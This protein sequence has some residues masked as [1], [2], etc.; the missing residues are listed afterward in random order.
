MSDGS[1]L[2]WLGLHRVSPGHWTFTATAPLSRA[3]RKFYGGTGVA[4]ATAIMEA[5]T[6]RR[7]IWTTVQFVASADEGDR[8]DCRIELQA[9]G[10]RSSQVRVE[11]RVEDRLV[12]SAL[13][14]T[15]EARPEQF[16]AQFRAMPDVPGPEECRRWTP[17]P[18]AHVEHTHLGW[19][20][21]VDA[22]LADE[23]G[24]MWM[25]LIDRSL[26][27]PAL[28]FLADIVPSG[29]VRATGR[30]GAGT[31]LDNSVRFGPEPDGNWLLIDIDPYLISGGYVHGGARL[32]STSGRLLGVASQTASVILFD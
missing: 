2:D 29:V 23:S 14:A 27:G 3:D 19:L 21:I 26:S 13:G 10:K 7:A 17:R 20:D 8:F 11:G 15:G 5:E 25:R 9:A 12:F 31:S 4:V 6:G 28:A 30:T 32:W 16:E 18:F 22:R 24:S 1:D